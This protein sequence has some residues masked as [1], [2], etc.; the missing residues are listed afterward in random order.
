MQPSLEGVSGA[1]QVKTRE[2][3]ERGAEAGVGGMRKAVCCEEADAAILLGSLPQS[4]ID[5]K[6]AGGERSKKTSREARPAEGQI[7]SPRIW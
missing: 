1:G 4:N 5:E 2:E 6:E 7:K 3:T